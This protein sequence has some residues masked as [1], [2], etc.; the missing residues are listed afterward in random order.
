MM[1][2][3]NVVGREILDSRGN[4]TVEV[5]ITLECGAIGLAAVPSGA[6]TGENEALELR[7]GDKGRYLGKGVLKAVENVNNAIAKE[8]IGMD[9]SN[10]VALDSK[11]LE[12]DGTKT[13]SKLGANAMLGVSLA[14]A[15]AAAN[16]LD[17]PLYRYIGG[18][19]AKTLPVP[20]MNII[21]GG[22][23]SDAPIAFQEFMIRPIGAPSFREGLRM[24]AEV[25][26][27]LKKVLSK[28]NL[29][30]AVGDEGG[31][32]PALDGT[33]DA[34]NSII[35]AIK[36]AGYKPGRAEDGGD[37]SIALDCAASEFFSDGVYDYSKFEGKDGAK[38]NSEEQAAYLA[39]LVSKFPIDSIEDGMDEGDW[40]GWVKLNASIGD[41]CQ[42]VGDDLFVTNV[43][44]LQKGI[45]LA[46]AN[47]I[48]IKVN[49]I[50]TLTE[51]LDAIE[52]A[53]RA[54]YTS[55][56]SHRSGETE[57]STI[58]DIAV[59]T[60]SGQ[61]K[62]GSLSRSDRMAKYNQL[63]RIEEQL[64]A[65]AIYGYKKVYKK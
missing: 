7:D 50:G 24:G 45:E 38:R 51:T 64:G 1:L 37:V 49:Q 25:F 20:M 6:S 22:S 18:A 57:D 12:L 4:P 23:H 44:Y 32:A 30:T 59:A 10:Q 48:L 16:A 63:L 3:N 42:L 56:T 13:K 29:S 2:I 46:A 9:A 34:L 55:V 31:F 15:K 36:N 26:H 19:N 33:E 62:T 58:A 54:G 41:K 35:E 60:N 8:I 14:V 52:M 39:E 11:L 53:H 5:E 65:A 43:E 27:S 21:N 28:R 40:D 47:S 17:L 61:I